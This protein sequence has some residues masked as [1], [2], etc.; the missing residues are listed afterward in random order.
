MKFWRPRFKNLNLMFIV[1]HSI[2]SSGKD[3]LSSD[4]EIEIIQ[5]GTYTSN[6][7]LWSCFVAYNTHKNEKYSTSRCRTSICS[8]KLNEY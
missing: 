6:F 4:I 3:T 8:S 2:P 7:R 1:W 5:T